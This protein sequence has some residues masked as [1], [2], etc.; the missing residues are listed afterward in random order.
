[1][2]GATQQFSATATY[3]DGTTGNVTNIVQWTTQAAQV[4]TASV[5]GIVTGVGQGNT[6][7]SASSGAMTGST[8]LT[9][10]APVLTISSVSPTSGVAGTQVSVSGS[11]F[12]NVQ[13]RGMVW[14]GTIPGAVVSWSDTQVIAAV[15]QGSS[16]GVARIQQN[17]T[18]SNSVPFT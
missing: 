5:G 3:T 16:S 8:N 1:G 17:G 11:G 7:V 9:V 18:S 12:G 6:V 4:A 15:A 13:G 10:T 14:L 2:V